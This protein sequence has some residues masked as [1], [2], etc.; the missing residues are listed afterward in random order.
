MRP[1]VSGFPSERFKNS[2]R[3]WFASISQWSIIQCRR[4]VMFMKWAWQP[5]WL[6]GIN[7]HSKV[8]IKKRRKVITFIHPE[9]TWILV[10][11]TLWIRSLSRC[12]QKVLNPQLPA[13]LWQHYMQNWRLKMC[14][15]FSHKSRTTITA[16]QQRLSLVCFVSRMT[17]E[18]LA[19]TA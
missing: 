1:E 11:E 16:S 13:T 3:D 19:V 5:K 15:L 10:T 17:D 7:R 14:C 2:K 9:V 12:G 4:R 6:K 18:L 8:E